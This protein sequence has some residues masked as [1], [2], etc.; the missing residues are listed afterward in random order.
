M[1]PSFTKLGAS[2]RA[3]AR[4][5]SIW[6]PPLAVAVLAACGATSR[7]EDEL[8]AGSTAADGKPGRGTSG[9]Q[10]IAGEEEPET[11]PSDD[12]GSEPDAGSLPDLDIVGGA[13]SGA[14][15]GSAP[16][17]TAPAPVLEV[18]PDPELTPVS[19]PSDTSYPPVGVLIDDRGPVRDVPSVVDSVDCTQV[20]SVTLQGQRTTIGMGVQF[21]VA[22][23]GMAE[24]PLPA[25]TFLDCVQVL[26]AD[27]AA[28]PA[29]LTAVPASNALTLVLV[30][31]AATVEENALLA[32][33]ALKLFMSRPAGER[34]ALYRWG[35]S[36]QQVITFTN[37]RDSFGDALTRLGLAD[38]APLDAGV[39]VTGAAEALDRV[40]DDAHAW[41]RSVVVLAPH[42]VAK[43]LFAYQ[44]DVNVLWAVDTTDV[45]GFQFVA[46]KSEAPAD[47]MG[48]VSAR[49]DAIRQAGFVVAGVC[50][51]GLVTQ[52]RASAGLASSQV[53]LKD[54][55]P[56]EMTPACDPEQVRDF[57]YVDTDLV[58]LTF[59]A[60]QREIYDAAVQDRDDTVSFAAQARLSPNHAVTPSLANLRGGTSLSRCPDNR[61]NL[62]IDLEG[63]RERFF[64]P[65]ESGSVGSDEFYL[66]AMCLDPFY[67]NQLTMDRLMGSLGMF[68]SG[69]K[70]VELR[71]DG[72]SQG[73]Y[74]LMEQVKEALVRT[75]AGLMSVVR[76]RN[77]AGE[78]KFPGDD[79]PDA[80]EV[81]LAGF[82]ALRNDIEG[83]DG[84]ER[85][86]AL[87][88]RLDLHRYL[89]FVAVQSVIHNADWGDEPTFYGTATFGPEGNAP[90]FQV[91]GWDP[92]DVLLGRCAHEDAVIVD[93]FGLLGCAEHMLDKA[94][95]GA[96]RRAEEVLDDEVY[97]L[98]VDALEIVLD[99]VTEERLAHYYDATVAELLPFLENPEVV[100]VMP[101]WSDEEDPHGAT[102]DLVRDRMQAFAERR[103]YLREQLMSYRSSR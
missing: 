101:D 17:D 94:I 31:P 23:R 14:P 88:P 85:L 10:L 80:Q 46:T 29:S 86:A 33:A 61:M 59:D 1:I 89:F 73:A 26:R 84:S 97:A 42:V 25:S 51:D 96:D 100:A 95:F 9:D 72:Q 12:E 58:E 93:P 102:V 2:L 20:G 27:G 37:H 55:L 54:A 65:E 19:L 4:P 78:V 99:Y 8:D 71:V 15:V 36:L 64:F 70:L 24:L 68:V 83:L 74:L 45:S 5:G 98:Y 56:E 38:G 39:A 81:A 91:N 75:Q 18:A 41:A 90:Y 43:D 49:L 21:R 60:E 35:S 13:N 92:D 77:G 40:A 69:A 57:D 53:E 63:G 6:I 76:R 30:Q 28:L 47:A 62:S 7:V 34:V 22:L 50:G 66:T 87:A 67:V 103:E 32:D 52:A 11:R 16:G 3:I 48:Y 79:D 44:R 82:D